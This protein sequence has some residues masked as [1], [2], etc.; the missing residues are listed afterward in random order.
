ME[1]T[2]MFNGEKYVITRSTA[3]A[4]LLDKLEVPLAG[5]V[6]ERNREILHPEAYNRT[7][8]RDGDK[9]ELIRIVGGG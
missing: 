7:M 1:I 6:V 2:I 3:V 8:L 4:D 5:V 9:L